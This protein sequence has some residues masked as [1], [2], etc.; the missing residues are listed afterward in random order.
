MNIICACDKRYG[1]G[2][3]GKLPDW[4]LDGDLKRFKKLTVGNGNNIVIMGKNTFESL[5][6]KR[7]PDR[8]NIVVSNTLFEIYQ[9]LSCDDSHILSLVSY[10]YDNGHDDNDGYVA[11]VSSIIDAYSYALQILKKKKVYGE[12]WLIGGAQL[13]ESAVQQWLVSCI[14]LTYV[15]E[16]YPCDTFLLPQTITYIDKIRLKY[17]PVCISD[18]TTPYHIITNR[19]F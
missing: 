6:R 3:R 16:E 15:D 1:I 17:K 19:P 2:F 11:F 5:G 7:L 18:V 9:N 4:T 8:V 14:H 13:Y 12:I 10:M